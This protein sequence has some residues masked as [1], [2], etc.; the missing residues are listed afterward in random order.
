MADDAKCKVEYIHPYGRGFLIYTDKPWEEGTMSLQEGTLV[1]DGRERIGIPLRFIVSIDKSINLPVR[2]EGRAFLLIEH[3][4]IKRRET[5][6]T[7][8]SAEEKCI[9]KTRFEILSQIVSSMNITYSPGDRWLPGRMLINNGFIEFRG[10]QPVKVPVSDITNVERTTIKHGL[11]KVGVIMIHYTVKN[12]N[13]VVG[14]FVQPMKRSFFWQLLQQIVDDYLN[15]QV[16]NDLSNLE[17]QVLHLILKEWNYKDIM[18]KLEISGDE[19]EKITEKLMKYRLINK[20][21]ILKATN[22]GKKIMSY[23]SEDFSQ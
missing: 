4:D 2:K 19:M 20:I 22:R 21:V 12:E 5:I 16:I 9:R 3:V 7:L 1:L 14:L 8:I 23:L 6:Y 10:A 11:N 13:R 18:R 17:R 15:T